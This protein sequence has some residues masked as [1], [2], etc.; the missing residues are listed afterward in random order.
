MRLARL[1]EFRRLVYTPESAPRLETL[2]A[3]IHEIPGGRV[4]LGR[5]Y[6]DLDEYDHQTHLRHRIDQQRTALAQDPLLE[7]LL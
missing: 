1:S 4:E 3:H 7:G 6:V 2:R 5:Y